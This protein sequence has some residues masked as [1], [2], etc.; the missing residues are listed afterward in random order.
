[1]LSLYQVCIYT[2]KPFHL[3]EQFRNQFLR[4]QTWIRPA[5]QLLC[6]LAAVFPSQPYL[7][8]CVCVCVSVCKCECECMCVR[9]NV[10]VRVCVCVCVCVCACAYERAHMFLCVCA[11]MSVCV[12]MCTHTHNLT[13]KRGSVGQSEGLSIPRSSVRFRLKS[14]TSNSH[15]FE[16]HRPSNKGTKLLLKVIKAII[17]ITSPQNHM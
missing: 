1:M 16:L 6:S 9:S 14:D 7:C 4:A 5:L 15:E 3:A 2:Y 10:C 8:A 12:C 17:I 13:C 11:R